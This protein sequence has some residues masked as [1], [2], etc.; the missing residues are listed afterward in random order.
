MRETKR[1]VLT[2]EQYLK[3][4]NCS[5]IFFNAGGC[6]LLMTDSEEQS[7][8]IYPSGTKV[9]LTN[10]LTIIRHYDTETDDLI[11]VEI[12]EPVGEYNYNKVFYMMKPTGVFVHN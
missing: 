7:A 12:R 4:C 6:T 10:N 2:I 3:G 9:G 8:L 1:E 11:E 5:C